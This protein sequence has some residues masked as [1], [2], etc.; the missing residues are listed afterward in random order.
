MLSVSPELI[1]VMKN[2]ANA[3]V[4]FSNIALT[5]AER[6]TTLNLNAARSALTEGAA[7]SRLMLH[8]EG[9]MTAPK[10]LPETAT[11]NALAYF[12]S[13]QEIAAETQQEVSKLMTS[14]LATQGN[15]MSEAA[16]WFKGFEALKTLGHQM[17]EANLK[18]MAGV[19]A[20]IASAKAPYSTKR[21]A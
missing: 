5:G 7:A 6:L 10:A 3:L 1:D 4:A 2:N 13:V 9:A 17:S 8:G 16:N 20:K 15:G 14:F 12:Q 18:A 21:A 11:K 19:T